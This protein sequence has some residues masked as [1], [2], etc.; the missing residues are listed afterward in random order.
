M[1]LLLAASS[2]RRI[3]ERGGGGGAGEFRKFEITE[4]QNEKFPAQNQVCFSAQ[5]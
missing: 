1:L 4:D 5:T 2:V 3:F